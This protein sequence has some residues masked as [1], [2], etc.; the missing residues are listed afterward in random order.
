MEIKTAGN[1]AQYLVFRNEENGASV[2]SWP[3]E[4][5]G[6]LIAYINQRV[7]DLP[8]QYSIAPHEKKLRGIGHPKG[9]TRYDLVPCNALEEV[10]LT[11]QWAGESGKHKEWSWMTEN[12]PWTYYF[13]SA[14]R[15]VWAWFRGER[16]DLE[17]GRHHL[18]HA[19][20][21]FMFL[22]EHDE[23]T[24]HLDDRPYAKNKE[25]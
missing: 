2:C 25:T 9:K 6:N 23:L 22:I 4:E 10:A 20:A 5:W 13:A 8:I 1:G 7:V 16:N 11:L 21:R 14:L 15:H 12:R 18:A 17:S 3:L 19:I 24:P